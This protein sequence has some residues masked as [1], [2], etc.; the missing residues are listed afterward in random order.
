M[1]QRTDCHAVK[2]AP[3]VT[4]NTLGC[5]AMQGTLIFGASCAMCDSGILKVILFIFA[6]CFGYVTFFTAL[7]VYVESYAN[8]PPVAKRTVMVMTYM[9][10]ASWGSFPA[11]FLMGPEG[12]GHMNQNWSTIMHSI[13]DLFSKNL[14]GVYGWYL[15][16]QVRPARPP[17]SD[18]FSPG[19]GS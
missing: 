5:T 8:V 1:S 6:C 18:G 17:L 7:E 10:F 14:W 16:I 4:L 13:A 19:G 15:R 9:F 3:T 11:L 12:F 2:P